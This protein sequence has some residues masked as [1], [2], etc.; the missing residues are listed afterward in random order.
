MDFKTAENIKL[1]PGDTKVGVN[2]LFPI[3]SVAYAND[4]AIPYGLTISS[5]VVTSSYN[6]VSITDMIIGS[7]IL[8]GTNL[9]IVQVVLSYPSTTMALITNK[10]TASLRFILTLSDTSTREFDFRNITI[11]NVI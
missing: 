3:E 6:G 4:G 9:N 11:G 10:I 2:F 7:P 5:V 8:T 1:Q